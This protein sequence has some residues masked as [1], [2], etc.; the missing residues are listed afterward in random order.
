MVRKRRLRGGGTVPA[1][2]AWPKLAE[3]KLKGQERLDMAESG[4]KEE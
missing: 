2:R 1:A 4:P 3:V